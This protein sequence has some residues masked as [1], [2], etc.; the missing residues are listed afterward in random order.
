[1]WVIAVFLILHIYIGWHNDIMER[2]GLMS[3]IFS[4]FKS[5]EK[6]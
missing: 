5:I 6:K 1:M 2:N 3:S 4:G